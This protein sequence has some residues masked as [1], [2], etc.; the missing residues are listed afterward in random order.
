M[1]RFYL[2]LKFDFIKTQAQQV[3]SWTNNIFHR[4]IVLIIYNNIYKLKLIT[5][6]Y[7]FKLINKKNTLWTWLV[8]RKV[9]E[10]GH[11]GKDLEIRNLEIKEKFSIGNMRNDHKW[12]FKS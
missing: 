11:T 4:N 5:E 2:I 10:L 3:F 8:E 7:I 9:G 1:L 12:F 6:N